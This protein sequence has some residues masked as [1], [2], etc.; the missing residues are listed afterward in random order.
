MNTLGT[1]DPLFAHGVDGWGVVLLIVAIKV[2]VGFGALMGS[3]TLMIWFERKAISDMQSRIGPQRW[4]PFGILQTLAD[5]IKLF[6]KEDLIPAESDRFVF[7]LA[8][9]LALVPAVITF[10]VVPVGG[11]L[12]IAGHV[13]MLQIA[14]PPMG[15][16]LLLAMSG[17]SVYGVMLA[18]WASGSKYPLISS[19]RAS[20]QMISYEAALGITI[21]TIVLVTGSLSTHDIVTSQGHWIWHWNVIRLGVVPFVIFWMAIT[22]ELGRPPFD[23]VEADSELVGGFNTEYSSI[24][25]ALFYMAEFMNTITMS[26][27]IVTL[28]FGGPAG[29]VP[30]VSHLRWVFPIV[31]F[32]L[33]TTIFCFCYIWFRAALPRFRY[34][35]V[36]DLGWK[37]L[38]PLSL[39]WMLIVAGFL[40]RPAYGFIMAAV[41]MLASVVLGRAFILGQ[42]RETGAD[43]ILPPVGPRPLP[44]EVLRS[45][46][47]REEE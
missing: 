45:W 2:L 23:V 1:V 37:R 5:G 19:V 27:I 43:S 4:G 14:N 44:P 31:W 46:S 40:L 8:P 7:K 16:L 11:T 39:G 22:A 3:V 13:V 32:V 18:G 35:Q 38:I 15:I 34:D 28:F 25:F 30:P 24:R 47:D 33:K 42:T 10:A 41:V 20:A 36:M 29:W 9:Y 6:F 26:A 17:I 12:H 21:V